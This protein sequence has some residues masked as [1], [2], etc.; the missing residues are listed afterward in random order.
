MVFNGWFRRKDWRLVKYHRIES[1]LVIDDDDD[2]D[3]EVEEEWHC[4][5]DDSDAAAKTQDS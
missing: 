2:D 3:D 4:D 1:G 5:N